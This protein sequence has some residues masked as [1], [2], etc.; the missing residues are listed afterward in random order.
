[1]ESINNARR[2]H[3]EPSGP[4]AAAETNEK[5]SLPQA[6]QSNAEYDAFKGELDR[7][8]DA[9]AAGDMSNYDDDRF[10]AI[11]ALLRAYP[12]QDAID[13]IQSTMD[14]KGLQQKDLAPY[15]GGQNRASEVLSRKRPLTI[16]MM[17][18]LHEAYGISYDDLMRQT[19]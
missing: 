15:L 1:M 19:K 16:K 17:R 3:G 18:A 8:H 14:A 13:I 5:I 4:A 2:Q 9:F 6:I 10:R 7:M 11:V 12:K